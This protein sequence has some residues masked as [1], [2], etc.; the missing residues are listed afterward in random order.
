MAQSE[1]GRSRD[2]SLQLP[3]LQDE[4]TGGGST[5]RVAL[6]VLRS[7]LSRGPSSPLSRFSF[8]LFAFLFPSLSVSISLYPPSVFLPFSL[9]AFF[10]LAPSLRPSLLSFPPSFFLPSFPHLLPLIS[11]WKGPRLSL[12][13]NTHFFFSL[14]EPG[15][16]HRINRGIKHS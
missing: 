12:S 6:R 1:L 16:I 3:W 9:F 4:A 14:I 10:F 2:G 15:E 13:P 8:L 7:A 5:R 11:P